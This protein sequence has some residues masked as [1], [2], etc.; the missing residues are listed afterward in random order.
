MI[1]ASNMRFGAKAIVDRVDPVKKE[2]RFTSGR[3]VRYQHLVSTMALDGLLER[4]EVPRDTLG[5]LQKAAEGLVFSSTIVLGLGIRG[6]R[7]SRIGDKCQYPLRWLTRR[8]GDKTDDLG[9]LYFPEDN[10][11]FYRATIFSNYSDFNVPSTSTKLRTTRRAESTETYDDS[12]RGGPY[13]SIMFE[14]CQSEQRH[15]DL[16]NL[17]EETIKGAVSTE[18]IR[19]EDEIVS[20]YQRRFDH[21]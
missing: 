4:L 12:P 15:V 20:T 14:V 16:E 9:W 19:P 1:P 3:T 6:E 17:L 21:G 10:T 2:V 7:P 13:W 18:L 5:P 11:P 8:T